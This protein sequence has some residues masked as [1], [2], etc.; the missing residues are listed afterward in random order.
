MELPVS[1][2]SYQP[3]TE[4]LVR[5]I[6]RADR[7]LARMAAEETEEDGFT[8]YTHPG[9]PAIHMCNFAAELRAP[10]D[11]TADGLLD[12]IA[13]HFH[14]R[15]C[16]CFTLVANE[17]TW[18]DDLAA[19]A[20]RRG[21]R[22]APRRLYL[23]TDYRP[24]PRV[25]EQLQII[26]GR[27]AYAELRD[28][29]HARAVQTYDINDQDA[30]DL[31]AAQIDHLDEPR[32]ETFLGRL[33]GQ[34]VGLVNLVTLGQIGVID[35]RGR[36]PPTGSGHHAARPRHGTLP[37]RPVRAGHPRNRPRQPCRRETL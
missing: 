7:I 1:P 2:H 19:A 4:A 3:S 8:A 29:H 28:F 10:G 17:M 22:P 5:A 36:H 6:K 20:E 21:Y 11:A 32:R 9:R 13:A 25:N 15:G 30:A 26:P 35:H 24:P 34:P 18:P 23:L 14:R 33:E 16:R 37:A 31:A 27:A 12:A